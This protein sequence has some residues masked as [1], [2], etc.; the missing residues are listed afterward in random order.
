M[1]RQIEMIFSWSS[2]VVMKCT[3]YVLKD[4]SVG[5]TVETKHYSVFKVDETVLHLSELCCLISAL[6][7]LKFQ[8][9]EA[10]I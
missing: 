4:N 5:L 2:R 7:V 6:A 3:S 9:P 10:S 1:S 8:A